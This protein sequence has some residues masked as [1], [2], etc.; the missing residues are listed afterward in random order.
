MTRA[1]IAMLSASLALTGCSTS[2]QSGRALDDGA[3]VTIAVRDGRVNP[4]GER[5]PVRVG[6]EVTLR[7]SSDAEEQIHVHTQPARTY[8]VKPGAEIEPTFTVYTPGVVAIEAHRLD[9]TIVRL[10]VT[11]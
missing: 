4:E 5:V 8:D 3:V 9:T 2:A 11:S 1:L 6:Q 10:I 7:I